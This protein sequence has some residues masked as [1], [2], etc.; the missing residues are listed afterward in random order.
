MPGIRSALKK[1]DASVT[2]ESKAVEVTEQA[3]P[4]LQWESTLGE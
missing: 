1:G 2:V 3:H 4:K